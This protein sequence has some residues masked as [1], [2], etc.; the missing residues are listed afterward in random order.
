V[1][2]N[3]SLRLC[4]PSQVRLRLIANDSVASSHNY[5][6][7]GLVQQGEAWQTSN[8][9]T[10]TAKIELRTQANAGRFELQA[11]DACNA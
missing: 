9:D 10:A 5:A 3:R 8:F 7:R 4:V 2:I 6:Q 1:R 11:E